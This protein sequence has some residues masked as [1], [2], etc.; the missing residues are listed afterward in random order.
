M[1]GLET[2][3]KTILE[4]AGAE[5]QAIV[6]RAREDAARI[7]AEA[8]AATDGECE[9]I[10]EAGRQRAEEIRLRAEGDIA[11]ERR[12]AL[13]ER[14]QQ[15]LDEVV[16]AAREA[17]LGEPVDRYFEFLIQLAQRSAEKG[18]G[19]MYLSKRDLTRMPEGFHQ[20]LNRALPEGAEIDIASVARPI[21]GGFILKYGDI[22]QNCSL[23]AIFDENRERILD[24]AREVLFD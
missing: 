11:M 21:E 7:L 6:E 5:A 22:E 15:L 17:V 13:L 9:K 8:K 2:I 1:A 10:V 16:R 4:E 24:A 19:V 20:A 12:R 18:L 23:E 3:T 14:K